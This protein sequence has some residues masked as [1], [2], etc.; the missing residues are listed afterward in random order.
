MSHLPVEIQ[1]SSG[2]PR[3][4]ERSPGS[5][6][7]LEEVERRHILRVLEA[8]GGNKTQAA[9]IL[10]INRKTLHARLQRYAR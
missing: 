4:A 10:G 6:P 7:S 5:F 8:V 2:E 9:Q 1:Q 3:E